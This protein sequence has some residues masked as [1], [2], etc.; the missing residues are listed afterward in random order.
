MATVSLYVE[1][2][3]YPRLTAKVDVPATIVGSLAIHRT[4]FWGSGEFPPAPSKKG[5]WRVSHIATGMQACPPD[6]ANWLEGLK[7]A[8]VVEFATLWQSESPEFF[9]ACD[10]LTRETLSDAMQG[11]ELRALARDAIDTARNIMGESV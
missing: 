3:A 5:N 7:R 4:L 11:E 1:R 10:K 9:A 2:Y 8:Q 6:V